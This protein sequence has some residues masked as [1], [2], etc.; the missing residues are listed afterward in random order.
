MKLLTCWVV[1]WFK[2][3]LKKGETAASFF[4]FMERSY[5][6]FKEA[7]LK[8]SHV[9]VSARSTKSD[10]FYSL[11]TE[12][13]QTNC[14]F[15]L[16]MVRKTNIS[17]LPG[18]WC[19]TLIDNCRTNSNGSLTTSCGEHR[20]TE[21]VYLAFTPLWSTADAERVYYE[22]RDV[23]SKQQTSCLL[24]RF[25]KIRFVIFSP[26]SVFKSCNSHQASPNHV[27]GAICDFDSALSHTT[28]G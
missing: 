9:K 20:D 6:G 18:L 26:H 13:S 5:C 21:L 17:V 12:S 19:W 16:H 28:E 14:W 25:L 22:G 10:G 11:Q 2:Y 4:N 8:V 15:K 7:K 24:H 3:F 23:Q 1:F 27:S